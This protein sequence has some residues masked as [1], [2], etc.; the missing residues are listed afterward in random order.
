VRYVLRIV[1]ESAE[2]VVGDERGLESDTLVVD[3]A[4]WV[5]EA[6]SAPFESHVQAR[7]RHTAAPALVTPEGHGFRARF[8]EPQRALAPGQAAVVYVGERV[9]GGGTIVRTPM[10]STQH[11][12]E[13]TR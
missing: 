5:G 13:G 4:S 11:A 12:R 8:L 10:P 7:Y 9:L 3:R 2:V 1:P 6:P